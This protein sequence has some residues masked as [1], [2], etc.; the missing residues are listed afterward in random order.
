MPH[1]NLIK[2]HDEE[3]EDQSENVCMKRQK[4]I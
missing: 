1:Q 3:E 4:L 2:R